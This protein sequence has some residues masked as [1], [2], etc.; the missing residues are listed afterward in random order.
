MDGDESKPGCKGYC[1]EDGCAGEIR[2]G[3]MTQYDPGLDAEGMQRKL[4]DPDLIRNNPLDVQTQNPE[5]IQAS[6][7]LDYGEE[8]DITQFTP[9]HVCPGKWRCGLC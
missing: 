3:H 5:K 6:Y 9:D 4:N 1:A 8:C 7:P 2:R